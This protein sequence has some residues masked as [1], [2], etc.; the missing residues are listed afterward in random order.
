MNIILWLAVNFLLFTHMP[1]AQSNPQ[2][3]PRQIF[4]GDSAVLIL[5]LPAAAQNSGDII[6]TPRSAG[7]PLDEN[8]DFHRIVLEKRVTGSRLIIEFTPFAPGVLEFPVITAGEDYFSGLKVTVNSILDKRSAPV[9]SGPA[10]AL[11]MPGT[12]MMIYGFIA[13]LIFAILFAIWFIVKGKGVLRE[14]RIKWE[15][16]RL[17]VNFKRSEKRLHR[18]VLKGTDNRVIL[19]KLS[20]ELRAFLS[21]LTNYNCHSMTAREFENM[22][23]ELMRQTLRPS[24]DKSKLSYL[25]AYFRRCD[26]LRFSGVSINSHDLIM[27]LDEL[28]FFINVLEKSGKGK[29]A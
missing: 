7:F 8:I 13:A 23:A 15:R 5:P 2:L 6:L 11:A 24:L 21:I 9:L 19:D 10:S 4:V 28:Y 27:L 17:F 20:D 16:Y 14:L 12:A 25:S 1:Y 18:T 22:P 26:D 29:A 3:I